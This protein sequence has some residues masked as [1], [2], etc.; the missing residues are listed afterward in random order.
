MSKERFNQIKKLN[1]DDL[2]EYTLKL[3]NQ[4]LNFNKEIKNLIF[5]LE[6]GKIEK[7]KLENKLLEAEIVLKNLKEA[8]K[9]YQDLN[10]QFEYLNKRF[11]EIKS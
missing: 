11:K 1:E 2:K 4:L 8:M 3:K 6:N 5:D 9:Q 10:L 7:N